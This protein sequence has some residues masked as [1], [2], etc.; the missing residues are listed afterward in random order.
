MTLRVC[1]ERSWIGVARRTQRAGVPL[2]AVVGDIGDDIEEAYERG[3]SAI[4]S[5]NRVAVPYQQARVRAAEDLR[6]TVENIMRFSEIF[7]K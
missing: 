2:I 7:I 1:A 4:F 5:I 3:V 6:L